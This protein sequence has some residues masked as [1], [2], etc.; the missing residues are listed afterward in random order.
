MKQARVKETHTILVEVTHVNINAHLD[1]TNL[2]V[3]VI[4]RKEEK[5]CIKIKG[6]M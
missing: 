2:K 5:K 1:I 4:E 6:P 3:N